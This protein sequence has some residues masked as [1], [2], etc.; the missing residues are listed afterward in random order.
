TGH[1]VLSAESTVS[2]QVFVNTFTVSDMF[3][4]TYSRVYAFEDDGVP[5]AWREEYFGACFLTDQRVA[6]GANFDNDG[7]TT[8]EEYNAGTSPVDAGSAPT[9]ELAIRAIPKL[10]FTTVPGKTYR[11]LRTTNLEVP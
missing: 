4:K 11:I 5:F 2:A 8:L 9:I 1:I 3:T 7:Y 10:T 6:A